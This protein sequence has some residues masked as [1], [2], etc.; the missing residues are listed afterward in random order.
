[1]K[2]RVSFITALCFL[3]AFAASVHA[4][5][6]RQLSTVERRIDTLNRQTKEYDRDSMSRE[7]KGDEANN[8]ENAKRAKQ[9]RAEIEEDLKAIQTVYNNVLTAL[10]SKGE[11]GNDFVLASASDVK[12]HASRLKTNLSLPKPEDERQTTGALP[13]A[14]RR[15]LTELCKNIY[16]F[17]TNPIFETQTGLNVEH[18][19]NAGRSLAI[20]IDLAEKIAA[21][22]DASK[23]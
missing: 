19:T 20:I 11:I 22:A 12:K 16:E 5:S 9:I 1:M 4:Q 18:A 7:K 3:A 21:Q 8:V 6:T 23:N 2:R 10:Q 17:I 15:Q 14:T 13:S